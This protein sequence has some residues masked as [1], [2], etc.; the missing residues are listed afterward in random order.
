MKKQG[1]PRRELL[2]GGPL[3]VTAI[4]AYV[5]LFGKSAVQPP[6][7]GARAPEFF[8]QTTRGDYRGITKATTRPT[9]LN[10]WEELCV[11][12][13]DELPSLNAFAMMNTGRID[14]LTITSDKY[15]GTREYVASKGYGFPVLIDPDARTQRIYGIKAVPTTLV[16]DEGKIVYSR[17]RSMNFM[18]PDKKFED[19]IRSLSINRRA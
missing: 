19:M 12:C 6:N 3:A 18:Q 7:V 8:L 4:A 16:V 11:Y 17:I 13:R 1:I 14:V 9:L 2:Y 10:F 15:K 5:G